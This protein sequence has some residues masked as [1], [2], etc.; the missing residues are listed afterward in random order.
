M[1]VE[2]FHYDEGAAIGW[3][4]G[5]RYLI[6]IEESFEII[7]DNAGTYVY[8]SIECRGWVSALIWQFTKRGL[9]RRLA[10]ESG[11]LAR[12]VEGNQR[13]YTV[14]NRHKRRSLKAQASHRANDE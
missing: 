8:H 4:T 6:L 1:D 14:G 9:R 2:V 3:R 13:N 5:H 12:R 11:I 7:E 10:I